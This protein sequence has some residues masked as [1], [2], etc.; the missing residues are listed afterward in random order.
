MENAKETRF[1]PCRENGFL[2]TNRLSRIDV[3]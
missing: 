3:N 2:A 1:L